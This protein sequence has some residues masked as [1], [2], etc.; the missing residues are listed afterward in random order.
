MY[1]MR[2]KFLQAH[3][4]CMP[5]LSSLRIGKLRFL[6]CS[7]RFPTSSPVAFSLNALHH[8]TF[9]VTLLAYI[10]IRPDI[11]FYNLPDDYALIL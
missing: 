4:Q 9:Q 8:V 6:A 10:A 5:L 11:L 1:A 2:C 3:T 7:I